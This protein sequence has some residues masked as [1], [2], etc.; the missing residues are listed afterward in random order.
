MIWATI[1]TNADGDYVPKIPTTVSY[2]TV[3]DLDST[4]ASTVPIS[5]ANDGDAELCA[6]VVPPAADLAYYADQLVQW[7]GAGIYTAAQAQAL[8]TVL[9]LQWD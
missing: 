7:A 3:L 5:L 2:D 4:K 9:G 1:T 8:A 6:T